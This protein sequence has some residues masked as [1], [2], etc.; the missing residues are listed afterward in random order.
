ME[1]FKV[2]DWVRSTKYLHMAPC[3]VE[4]IFESNERKGDFGLK[5]HGTVHYASEA[6]LWQPKEGEWCWFCSVNGNSEL[7]QF[8]EEFFEGR[9]RYKLNGTNSIFNCDAVRCEPFIGKLPTFL[10]DR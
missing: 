2:G 1:E 6:E 9:Y 7:G 3:K 5:S 10:K 4:S 8:I